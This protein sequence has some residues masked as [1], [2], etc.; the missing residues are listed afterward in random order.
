MSLTTNL[1]LADRF[2]VVREA[3]TEKASPLFSVPSTSPAFPPQPPKQAP[4]RA[5]C[6]LSLF[7][8]FMGNVK[9]AWS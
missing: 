9:R 2:R 1:K 5:P 3:L 8:L 4:P 6:H 7:H